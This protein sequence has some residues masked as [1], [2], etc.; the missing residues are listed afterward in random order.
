[1]H[2]YWIGR[3]PRKT[4]RRRCNRFTRFP[5]THGYFFDGIDR[6]LGQLSRGGFVGRP[7]G[8]LEPAGAREDGAGGT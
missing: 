8:S 1:M 6:L 7:L 5:F 3:C 4:L 2:G